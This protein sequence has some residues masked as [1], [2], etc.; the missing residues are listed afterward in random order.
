MGV[1]GYLCGDIVGRDWCEGR[2]KEDCND[3]IDFSW[4]FLALMMYL[5]YIPFCT[6]GVYELLRTSIWTKS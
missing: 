6:Y 3:L 4:K 1:Y 2:G 5:Y